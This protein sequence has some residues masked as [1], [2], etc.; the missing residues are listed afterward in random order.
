MNR[1][2]VDRNEGGPS[3]S[4]LPHEPRS[5]SELLSSTHLFTVEILSMKE[6]PW[7]VGDDG[8]EHRRLEMEAKLLEL[9]KGRLN[10][11]RQQAFRFSVEQ[12]RESEFFVTDFHGL[13]SHV[14]PVSGTC[15]LVVTQGASDSPAELMQE[16]HCKQLVDCKNGVEVQLALEAER[17]YQDMLKT[18]RTRSL[19][20]ARSLLKL[21]SE[22][23]AQ[24]GEF[25]A[26]YL[27]ARL[28]PSFLESPEQLLPDILEWITSAGL[29]V[30]FRRAL[31]G[32]FTDAYS[33]LNFNPALHQSVVRA[34]FS[35]LLLS[36]AGP[37]HHELLQVN[38]YNLVFDND[39]PRMSA[40]AIFPERAERERWR[41]VLSHFDSEGGQKL[42]QWLNSGH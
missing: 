41:G 22:R 14:Q 29:S 39:V 32:G 31:L 27:W 3:F 38:L 34:F 33:L 42:S 8:L 17:L 25:F 20:F 35:L 36:E 6:A 10:L 2:S 4:G 15:Y 30:P 24:G 9:Y 40:Q 21:A 12:R 7:G 16:P 18:G 1:E 19:S 13:W 37:L 5:S 26:R 23:R 28:G 11:Q